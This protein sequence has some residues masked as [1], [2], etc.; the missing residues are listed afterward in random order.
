MFLLLKNKGHQLHVLESHYNGLTKL[1]LIFLIERSGGKQLSGSMRAT[2][3]GVPFFS[4]LSHPN[5]HVAF[6]LKFVA[7]LLRTKQPFIIFIV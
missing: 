7:L 4:F 5:Y 3:T 6:V 1:E 2:M